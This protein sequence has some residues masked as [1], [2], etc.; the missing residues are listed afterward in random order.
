MQAGMFLTYRFKYC[1][2]NIIYCICQA[3]ELERE[4]KKKLGEGAKQKSGGSWPTQG[5]LKIATGRT[6]KVWEPVM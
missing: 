3:N 6:Q 4:N 1:W 5:P 2:P